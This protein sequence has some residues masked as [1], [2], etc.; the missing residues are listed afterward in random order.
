MK[1]YLASFLEPENF[2]PGRLIGIVDGKKPD[3]LKIH[4]KFPPFTPDRSLINE[5]NDTRRRDTKQ[6]SENF[7]SEYSAQLEEFVSKVIS[8][9]EQLPFLDGDTLVSWERAKF[10][11]YRKILAPYLEKL[12]YEVILN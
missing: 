9:N 6:A 8:N 2:G 4:F 5:Y 12:G 10:T 1:I 11:N 3:N 7:V